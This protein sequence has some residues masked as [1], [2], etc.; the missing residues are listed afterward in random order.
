MSDKQHKLEVTMTLPVS[1]LG[2]FRSFGDDTLS[3]A[4]YFW[5]DPEQFA[6]ALEQQD[7][8]LAECYRIVR[9]TRQ[10]ATDLWREAYDKAG[11]TLEST[12]DD[13]ARYSAEKYLIEDADLQQRMR[14][15]HREG[16]QATRTA[17]SRLVELYGVPP[18]IHP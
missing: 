13:W 11:V 8:I 3:G 1:P 16:G 4:F 18:D 15:N 2:L 9:R 17:R 7:P 14:N 6:S 12:T 5:F 10:T